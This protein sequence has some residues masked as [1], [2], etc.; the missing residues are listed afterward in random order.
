MLN[1]R[2][3]EDRYGLEYGDMIVAHALNNL[4]QW[5]GEK[6]REVK[7]LLNQHLKEYNAR[8]NHA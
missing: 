8:H 6:A 1:M 3:C 4:M 7:Q 5:R 2:S